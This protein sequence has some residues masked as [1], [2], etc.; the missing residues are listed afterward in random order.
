MGSRMQGEYFGGEGRGT[1]EVAEETARRPRR[2][3]VALGVGARRQLG[4]GGGAVFVVPDAPT[5]SDPAGM[6][7]SK[8]LFEIMIFS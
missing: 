2:R 4:G 1:R 6:I 8:G 3:A 5:T 7:G